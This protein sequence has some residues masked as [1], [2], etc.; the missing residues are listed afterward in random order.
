MYG[1]PIRELSKNI[2]TQT[3]G[4]VT[5]EVTKGVHNKI[6]LGVEALV[7][8]PDTAS[9]Q[10]WQDLLLLELYMNTLSQYNGNEQ[11]GDGFWL[12]T[13]GNTLTNKDPVHMAASIVH[14]QHMR[15]Q[16]D[17]EHNT[18]ILHVVQDVSERPSLDI[19]D[20]LWSVLVRCSTYGALVDCL[21]TFMAEVAYN[22]TKVYISQSNVSWVAELLRGVVA[23][24]LAVP[25]F[26]GT[27]PIQL[28]IL[29]GVEKLRKDYTHIFS[30][31]N[32]AN[33]QQVNSY[34]KYGECMQEGDVPVRKGVVLRDT[35]LVHMEQVFHEMVVLGRLETLC[36]L[37]CL[38]PGDWLSYVSDTA[39][40]LLL[41]PD[42]PVKS[43]TSLAGGRVHTLRV[44][45]PPQV[46]QQHVD[47]CMPV[48]V[49]HV[50]ENKKADLRLV[51]R[52]QLSLQPTFP[53]CVCYAPPPDNTADGKNVCYHYT[54]SLQITNYFNKQN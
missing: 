3:K 2:K 22:R 4:Y 25:M 5:L 26:T 43:F 14:D 29:L 32:V 13:A 9:W 54:S 49:A 35:Q 53:P 23:G 19:T 37:L 34:L 44:E 28:L 17:K 21:N 39:V 12:P 36:E 8:H 52:L 15:L 10:L 18:D 24:V 7:G 41:G 30:Q 38:V 11:M 33:E 48:R 45:L 51:T 20:R 47:L 1:S 31:A 27:Q 40:E 6:T 46:V 16:H 42:S 50:L